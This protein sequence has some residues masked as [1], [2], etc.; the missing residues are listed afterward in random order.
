MKRCPQCGRE[1]P[2]DNKFCNVCG[3]R[4]Q[5]QQ[6]PQSQR[7][8]YQQQSPQS[9]RNPYFQQNPQAQG[10]P[11]LQENP[12]PQQ[13]AYSQQPKGK[14][15]KKKKK[16]LA[17]KIGVAVG[18]V[19]VGAVAIFV[20]KD[21]L[22]IGGGNEEN[23]IVYL[24]EDY[25]YE[26]VKDANKK[27]T[28]EIPF[29]VDQQNVM[30]WD[31]K[32]VPGSKY[33]YHIET[34]I[35]PSTGN[36]WRC[37]YGKLGSDA[38]KNEKYDELIGQAV[39]IDEIYII[40]DNTII[41]EDR[42]SELYYY[43]GKE[44]RP[45]AKVSAVYYVEGQNCIG[46]EIADDNENY[47][48]YGID[49]DENPEAQILLVQDYDHL[50]KIKDF[51]QI[52][53]EKYN[54]NNQIELYVAGLG[55]GTEKIGTL[56]WGDCDSDG[57]NAYYVTESENPV[58]ASDLFMDSQGRTDIMEELT[59][60]LDAGSYKSLYVY[61]NGESIQVSDK[62]I[63]AS[64]TDGTLL[65]MSL[66]NLGAFDLGAYSDEEVEN[67]AFMD[68]YEKR[69]YNSTIYFYSMDTGRKVN[70]TENAWE[71]LD[72]M[73]GSSSDV[74]INITDTNVLLGTDEKVIIGTIQDGKIDS[75]N[76]LSDDG[77]LL[78]VDD[79]KFYYTSNKHT[80]NERDYY[81]LYVYQDGTSTCLETDI[82][83]G[84]VT[85]YEDGKLLVYTDG[86]S[87]NG[88][89][90]KAE[91]IDEEGKKMAIGEGKNFIRCAENEFVYINRSDS[92]QS[93][94]WMYRN[95]ENIELSTTIGWI[96]S[97]DSMKIQRRNM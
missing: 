47:S 29:T 61:H 92:N 63:D 33:I 32:S 95:G 52:F 55:K 68:E 84:I 75:F 62:V 40:N 77:E 48:L 42:N 69:L 21:F 73:T 64:C 31:M 85:L 60:D 7:N 39:N 86:S 66:D 93:S 19:V 24:N 58:K 70:L 45:L 11:Y 20:G 46:Y 94:V 2:D 41:Y 35:E 13:P 26:L 30:R 9:Q 16:G 56:S 57:R 67:G 15:P 87:N 36:L 4:L 82:L 50:Y 38:S 1:Y 54:E 79:S 6:M 97:K 71:M 44:S 49:F 90:W 89:N 23:A 76:I 12:Y 81:D 22:P 88:G 5:G 3:G 8:P 72:N 83:E 78:N 25:K 34:E 18:V 14:E 53:Y 65:Y 37:E 74:T 91:L 59:E 17:V 51:Y 80:M 10:N 27:K 43:N 28:V 96:W